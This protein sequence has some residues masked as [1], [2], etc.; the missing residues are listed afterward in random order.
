MV[1]CLAS[2]EL[3]SLGHQKKRQRVEGDGNIITYMV[4]MY[5]THLF[6]VLKL[7]IS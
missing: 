4:H 6:N 1:R 7:K 5:D 3:W 2:V